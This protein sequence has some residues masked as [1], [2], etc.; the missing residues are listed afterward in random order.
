MG[1]RRLASLVTLSCSLMLSSGLVAQADPAPPSPSATAV[2]SAKQVRQAR[3]AVAA[4]TAQQK[5]LDAQLTAA[6]QELDRVTTVA[7]LATER[8]N[9]ARVLLAQRTAQAKKARAAAVAANNRAGSARL[10]VYQLA[11]SL[12]MQGGSLGG[13]ESMLGLGGTGDVARQAAD[14]EAVTG[15]RAQTFDDARRQAARAQTARRTASQAQ[16]QEQAAAARAEAAFTA[17]TTAAN[18]ATVAQAGIQRRREA[19]LAQLAQLRRTS[20]AVERGRQ[21]G[22]AALAEQAREARLVAGARRAGPAGSAELAKLPAARTAQ[23]ASAIAYARS[24]LGKPYVWA[25]DGPDSFDC[26]GLTMQAWN[27]AGRSLWHYTGDQYAQTARVPLRALQ[28]GDLVF[29]GAAVPSIHHVGLYIGNGKMI[30]APHTG[31]FVRVSSI[32]RG[33]LLPYGGRP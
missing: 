19:V 24:Q 8:Y 21:D 4:A 25:A 16:L 23:A 17:A 22:L 3:A 20:V 27:Q 31:A 12:Y 5:A 26:S 1:P 13:M 33:D 29:Y 15:F 7:E 14:M 18:T 32:Y 6:Q 9:Q 28:P 10:Q 2:P 30:E 11:A